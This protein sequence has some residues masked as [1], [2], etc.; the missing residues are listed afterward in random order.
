MGAACRQR[1]KIL[2]QQAKSGDFAVKWEATW[3]MPGRGKRCAMILMLASLIAGC[4]LTLPVRGQVQ[5]TNETFAGTATGYMDGAGDLTIVSNMD[6]TCT[7]NFVY[8][9]SR[10]GEG[11]F[12]CDDGRSGP[13]SFVSTGKRG[14]G[15]GTLGGQNFTFTFGD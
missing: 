15:Q 11:V 1:H 6:A 4:S 8:V 10:Q 9:N 7:G 14:T 5:N 3:R 13:F 12:N 2:D